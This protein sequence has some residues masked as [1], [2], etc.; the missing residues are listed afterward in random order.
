MQRPSVCVTIVTY[1]SQK[2]IQAC[3]ESVFSQNYWPLEV[4][5]VDNASRDNTLALLHRCAGPARVVRNEHNLGF[6]AAQ[7]QAIALSRSDWV[8]VL[9]PDVLLQP[10]F[11]ERLVEAGQA[12]RRIGTVCGKLLGIGRDFQ[13]PSEA[14]IDSAGIYF[15]PAMRHF[16]RGWGE[17]DDGRFG[18]PEYVFGAS[19]AAALYRRKMIVDLARDD[20]FFDPDFFAYREDADVAWRAQWLGWRCLYTPEAVAYHARSV[21]AGQRRH[22]PAVLNMHSVKNRFLMRIKN[23]S[24]GI[25]RRYWLPMTLRDVLVVGG[26]LL[27]EPSSLPAFWRL[28][29]CLPRALKKRRRLMARRRASDEAMA[30][31]FNAQPVTESIPQL[32]LR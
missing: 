14:H 6:A 26:C 27:Y 22:V 25:Y 5:I 2:Y 18:E 8:L 31:W 21:V 23:V 17:P 1:N 7:N 11:I 16:D 3:L 19:A 24:G 4:V 15:T 32:V 12:D 28:G 10:G 20:A 9:N 29:A 30:G 13:P